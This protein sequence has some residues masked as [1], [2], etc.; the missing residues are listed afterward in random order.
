MKK[1]ELLG[2][3]LSKNEQKKIMGGAEDEGG[4][5]YQIICTCPNGSQVN[6]PCG[7]SSSNCFNVVYEVCNGQPAS[8]CY[9]THC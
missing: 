6:C 1:L 2:R 7:V 9:T 3:S 8:G 5:G 4:S